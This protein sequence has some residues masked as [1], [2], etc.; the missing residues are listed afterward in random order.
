MQIHFV[1]ELFDFAA[2]LI[3]RDRGLIGPPG[4]GMCMG[5]NYHFF[6]LRGFLFADEVNEDQKIIG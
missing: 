4:P 5:I 3:I 1:E 6:L 2:T